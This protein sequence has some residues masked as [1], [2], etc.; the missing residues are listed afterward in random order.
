MLHY[1]ALALRH[2]WLRASRAPSFR[3]LMSVFAQQP[4]Y[5]FITGLQGEGIV[6]GESLPSEA[7]KDY[8]VETSHYPSNSDSSSDIMTK[9]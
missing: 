8:E 5:D 9:S 4:R 6:P 3:A 2:P 7:S 1:S